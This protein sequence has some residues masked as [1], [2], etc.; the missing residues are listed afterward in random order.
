MLTVSIAALGCAPARRTAKSVETAE[1]E[2]VTVASCEAVADVAERT[3]TQ[4]YIERDEEVVV[5]T[6]VFDTSLPVDSV[7]GTPPVKERT[8]QKRRIRTGAV[9]DAAGQRRETVTHEADIK[10]DE[11]AERQSSSEVS[12]KDAGRLRLILCG[13]G[14]ATVLFAAGWILRRRY[15]RRTS[16]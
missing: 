14:A 10:T 6:T 5:E 8:V 16:W 12:Q 7:T 4:T 1:T 15:G 11:H 9:Q 13:M 2:S 3:L